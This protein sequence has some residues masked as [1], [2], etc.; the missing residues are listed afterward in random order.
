[1]RRAKSNIESRSQSAPVEPPC[2]SSSEFE[3][4][5][6]LESPDLSSSVDSS[7][8]PS[9]QAIGSPVFPG[10]G[11]DYTVEG[12]KT[13]ARGKKW[14]ATTDEWECKSS[15]DFNTL[16]PFLMSEDWKVNVCMDILNG[17]RDDKLT[18]DEYVL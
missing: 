14:T 15:F 11:N 5:T 18:S 6:E 2:F 9:N 1:M 17:W 13:T 10:A 16:D 12:K 8:D 7:S 3:R 4:H